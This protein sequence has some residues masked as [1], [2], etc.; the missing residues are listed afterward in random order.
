MING[1]TSA[2]P[3]LLS[4]V[5]STVLADEGPT[6]L[7]DI[8][9]I[10]AHPILSADSPLEEVRG[11]A[12]ARIPTMPAVQSVKDW[13]RKAEQIRR[14][15]FTK[16]IFRGKAKKWRE[17]ETKVEWLETIDGG[18]GYK[19]RKLR[20]EA[21]PNLWIPALL[22][23]PDNL[24]GPAP[25]VMNVNGHEQVGKSIEYKQIRCINQAK[26]G[27]IALNPEWIG[28]GQLF[29]DNFLHYRMNQIDL[30]GTSGLAPF[31]LT[32]E[33][34]LDLLL[35]LEHAD[36]KRVAVAGLSGGGWQTL[37][38]SSLD[39]RVTLAN[40]V[41]GYSSF[42]TRIE[43]P[44]DLGD[45][46]Q[47]PTDMATVADYTH[48]TALR[49][50]RPTLL[51]YNANDNCCFIAAGAIPP[52]L[53]A[54]EPVFQLFGKRSNLRTH[55]NFIPGDHNYALDNRLQLYRMFGEHF[56]PGH[57]S[58]SFEEI[59][60]EGELK[61]KEQLYVELPGNNENFN[62]LAKSLALNLPT[63]A[64]I[65][66][67][68]ETI[69]EWQ[70]AGRSRL[71]DI[72]KA[73]H[74][75]V[76][77]TAVGEETFENGRATFWRL[78]IGDHWNVPATE[79]VRGEPKSTVL[80]VA[81]EGRKS[82][83]KQAM[84]LLDAGNR[85]VA[86]DPFDFGESTIPERHSLYALVVSCVGARP[87]G[88]QTSQMIAIARWVKHERNESVEV[89]AF[90]PRTSLFSLVAAALE[91]T[92]IEALQMTGSFG[93]LKEILEQ[94]MSVHTT[95]ELFC[96]GLLEQFDIQQLISLVAPQRVSL[97]EP[98]ERVRAELA[99][100]QSVYQTF[101][102]EFNPLQGIRSQ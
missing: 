76:K 38:I 67:S 31:Y 39:K 78:K 50:P 72:V 49:A 22:Y 2:V 12:R 70:A 79:L 56:F 83:S 96:F 86:I 54:A 25:V 89:H 80:L 44:K 85:V 77:A 20:Y 30:C 62:S 41:A 27:M 9:S 33:R 7:T 84:S 95:P 63:D 1:K 51:T 69:S 45:S 28:M 16:V 21:L 18:P 60:T 102:V 8:E 34:G 17:A 97:V 61:T 23:L 52:L 13:T 26:R 87:L 32:M 58:F 94:N 5:V 68:K 53:N 82:A 75:E 42:F 24:N 19:I 40:P 91:P 10:L 48:L 6:K 99:E 11:F 36:P 29:D 101:E 43:D 74:D 100:L 3:L 92:S 14:D 65:P 4:M 46:E 64:T 73:T 35:S 37:F 55:V 88:I 57:D 90:G 81:D 71:A 93:S 47:T 98:S 66:K 15:M 59:S